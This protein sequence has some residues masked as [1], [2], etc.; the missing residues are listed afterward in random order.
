MV[1]DEQLRERLDTRLLNHGLYLEKFESDEQALYLDYETATPGEGVPHREIGHVL[2]LLLDAS[3]EGWSV[4]DVHGTVY[5]LDGDE[6]GTWHSEAAW[7]RAH[8]DG[9]LSQVEYSQL[10]LDTVEES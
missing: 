3:E 8:E 9:D 10:V 5:S 1:T 4:R 6:R 7:M 2:N